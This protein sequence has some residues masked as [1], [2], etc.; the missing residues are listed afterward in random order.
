MQV[1]YL[2]FNKCAGTS[3]QHFLRTRIAEP[4]FLA[5]EKL[6]SFHVRASDCFDRALLHDPYGYDLGDVPWRPIKFAIFRDP[7]E[8]SYSDFEMICRWQ[9]EE[10]ND[11]RTRR[12]ATAAASG[13]DRLVAN[14]DPSVVGSFFNSMTM[15]LA[16]RSTAMEWLREARTNYA[17]LLDAPTEHLLNIAL[18]HVNDIDILLAV[19]DLSS[20]GPLAAALARHSLPLTNDMVVNKHNS[21]CRFHSL[22]D[23]AVT[24]LRRWNELDLKVWARARKLMQDRPAARTIERLK[25]E[26][27]S[28]FLDFRHGI[29]AQNIW[30]REVNLP[31]Y[32]I[33]TGNGGNTTFFLPVENTI[34]KFLNI[35]ITNMILQRQLDNLVIRINGQKV[36]WTRQEAAVGVLVTARVGATLLQGCDHLAVEFATE[37]L[38]P[39]CAHDERQ[40]GLEISGLSLITQWTA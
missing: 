2:H 19:D 4:Q 25:R 12:L 14:S 31:K 11:D 3:I 33:W 24:G 29:P 17:D 7:L 35:H 8:R 9:P 34:E 6:P 16:G 15:T 20:V 37:A 40:L 32:S 28:F 30:P 1:H 27:D 39:P 5:C 36:A 13:I 18:R 23:T 21:S 22:S 10:I 38:R 26:N